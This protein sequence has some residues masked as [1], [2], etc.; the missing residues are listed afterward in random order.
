MITVTGIIALASFI[1]LVI[2]YPLR[3]LGMHKANAELMKAHEAASAGVF[4]VGIV[5]MIL[6]IARRKE[7]GKR[8]M[9]CKIACGATSLTLITVLI[10]ACHM[11][12]DQER[13]MRDHRA[14][15]LASTIAIAAHIVAH[16]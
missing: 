2:K 11:T 5:H 10:A 13:K 14:L 3:K 8:S 9:P 7:F 15:S 12:E 6:V 1:A 4:G 16:E